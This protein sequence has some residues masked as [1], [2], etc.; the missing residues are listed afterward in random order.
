LRINRMGAIIAAAL[1]A[2]AIASLS[3]PGAAHAAVGDAYCS[4]PPDNNAGVGNSDGARWA[5]TFSPINGGYLTAVRLFVD[6]QARYGG[7]LTVQITPVNSSDL[8]PVFPVVPLAQATIQDSSIPL[9]PGYPYLAEVEAD[10]PN[11]PAVNASGK[12]AIVITRS[13][14]SAVLGIGIKTD[15]TTGNGYPCPD[16]SLYE[17]PATSDPWGMPLDGVDAVFTT[18][19]GGAPTSPPPAPGAQPTSTSTSTKKKKCKKSKKG[20][21]SAAAAKKKCKKKK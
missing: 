2:S 21:T 16:G 7:T 3:T 1:A 15:H 6:E 20:K 9:P 18:F 13:V 19:V 17:S 11:P 10:F 4:G 14:S 8:S 12:Y 5:Q